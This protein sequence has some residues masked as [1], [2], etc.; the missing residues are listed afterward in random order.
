ML[1]F[2]AAESLRVLVQSVTLQDSTWLYGEMLLK[3]GPVSF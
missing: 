1:Q 3:V 2:A